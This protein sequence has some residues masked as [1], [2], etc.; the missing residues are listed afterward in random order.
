[1]GLLAGCVTLP[2]LQGFAD[3]TSR[4]TS[5]IQ[6]GYVQGEAA[7]ARADTARARKLGQVW[8]P[9]QQALTALVAYSDALASLA[10]QANNNAKGAAALAGKFQKV[11]TYLQGVLPLSGLGSAEV[12]KLVE[13][14]ARQLVL[15]KAQKDLSGAVRE[16]QPVLE[17]V[18][19]IIDLNL[20]EL[21]TIHGEV[22]EQQMSRHWLRYSG[23]VAVSE[24][25]MEE[26]KKALN[27]LAAI[28]KY[29][30]STK[31]AERQSF[32]DEVSLPPGPDSTLAKRL[33]ERERQLTAQSRNA[34]EVIKNFDAAYR[35]YQ[36]INTD[37]TDQLTQGRAL[38]ANSRLALGAWVR[39]HAGL[40]ES[41]SLRQAFSLRE[42]ATVVQAID[43]VYQFYNRGP[44][45]APTTL[46]R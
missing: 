14:G 36:K 3:E 45:P 1:V 18:A 29:R 43:Q 27:E 25:K 6:K 2:N 23:I 30:T 11:T 31:R 20:A 35:D 7:L 24:A 39:A 10:N 16:S 22:M 32:L 41:L 26:N 4:M 8:R 42:L 33:D 37:L 5:A 21:A 40:Q 44:L 28:A 46:A 15:M 12:T 34:D 19:A 9:T 38:V 17:Q 13:I